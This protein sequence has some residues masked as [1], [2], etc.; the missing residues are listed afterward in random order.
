[1]GKHRVYLNKHDGSLCY[2]HYPLMIQYFE[3]PDFKIVIPEDMKELTEDEYEEL[4]ERIVIK[5]PELQLL[6]WHLHFNGRSY[7]SIT[8]END[9]NPGNM[10]IITEIKNKFKE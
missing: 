6:N 5:I 4:K 1:M 9:L 8:V 2:E 3:I 7:F 10:R